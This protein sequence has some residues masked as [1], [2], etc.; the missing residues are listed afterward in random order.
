ML[1]VLFLI[2]LDFRLSI[3][4]VS[5]KILNQ[6]KLDNILICCFSLRVDQ[7]LKIIIYAKCPF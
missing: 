2:T 3:I 5:M 6:F 7:T 1:S 4:A